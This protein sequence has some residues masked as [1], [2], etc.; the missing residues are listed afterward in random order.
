MLIRRAGRQES[1]NKFVSDTE[2]G[3]L[4]IKEAWNVMQEGGLAC[5]GKKGGI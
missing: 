2:L 1:I 3:K 4:A 5:Q